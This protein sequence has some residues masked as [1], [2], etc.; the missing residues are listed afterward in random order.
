M[1]LRIPFETLVLSTGAAAVLVLGL[2]GLL[3]LRLA[4][5][6]A[7]AAQWVIH[8]EEVLVRLAKVRAETLQAELSTQNYRITGDRARLQE[9]DLSVAERELLLQQIRDRVADNP[10]QVQRWN[11]LRQ[12]V[13][14][15]KRLSAQVEKLRD[16]L[17]AQAANAFVQSAPLQQTRVRVYQTLQEMEQHERSLLALRT[18]EQAQA[19]QRVLLAGALSALMLLLLL[20]AAYLLVLRQ[21]RQTRQSQQ[22]LAHSEESLAA[23]LQSIGDGVLATDTEGRITRMNPVAER[24]TGWTLEQARGRAVE[25]VF[26]IVHEDTRQSAEVP[27]GR[28]LRTG[29]IHE[30]AEH[31]LLLARDGSVC[32]IADSAAPIRDAE[33]QLSGVVIVFR[34]ET[35][36]RQLKQSIR[37][38]NHLLEQ[39]VLERTEQLRH[40]EEH[41]RSVI[42]SVPAL[43]AFVDAEQRYVYVN[44]QYQQRFAPEHSSIIGCSVAEVLGPERYAV[45]GPLIQRALQGQAQSYDWQPFAGVW[46]QVNYLPMQ[47]N[48]GRVSGYYVLGTD[49][50]E[51]KQFEL[52]QGEAAAV[53]SNSYEAIMVVNAE[54]LITR[55][56][57]AFTRITGYSQEEV[58]G[59]SPRLLSSGRHDA[60]FFREFWRGLIE[61]GA[62]RGEI[63]NRRKN[64]DVFAVLQSVSVVRDAQ[65][66]LLHYVSV[67]ADISQIK[68]HEAELD[69]VAN[70]DSL[71]HLPNRR[72]LSDR[73]QQSILRADRSGKSCA[74][75]F[76][77][78]DG[79]KTVNDRLG[80]AVGDQIL[81]GMARHLSAI[82][83]A[84][85]TLAR[86]GGDEFVVLL[87]EVGSAE[88]CT[89]ILERMLEAAR[90][91]VQAR[92]H[93]V[94]IS[95]SVGVSLYPSDNA[96]P[97]ILLRHADMAMYLAKQAGKNRYQLFD[98]QIDRIAQNH[99]EY[100]VQMQEA[101]QRQEFMLYYQPKVD[102][103]SGAMTGA[104]ALIRW[105][106]PE[107]GLLSPAEFLPH[108]NGSHLEG[109]FGEWVLNSALAQM[110]QWHLQGLDMQVSVN[111]SANHLQQPDFCQRLAQILAQ[112]PDVDPVNLELEVLETAALADMDLAVEILERCMELGVRFAMDD[113]GT[114]Y[115]SLTYLRKLPL[116]TLK[117]D[118]SFV[119]NMLVDADDLG[120]VRGIIELASVFQRQVVAEGVETLEI[121]ARLRSLGC[122]VVQ[123]YGIARPMPAT[124]L[125]QWC[126]DWGQA[127]LWKGI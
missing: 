60:A 74:I 36:A 5:D 88:E 52:L 4:E 122:R 47:D 10:A 78:L 72:L 83:R 76:L 125:P 87:S 113:F 37:E 94:Q 46:Q 95:A 114:G 79:F 57:A 3:T 49:I 104:E 81:V 90:I 45:A 41:L 66:Q 75:C 100:L 126:T 40:S 53:F 20:A 30:M 63:W 61:D 31:T 91:P 69:R 68:A 23:T 124:A 18:A 84:E 102:L 32:P 106:Q 1:K 101:L 13:D 98:P 119:R 117:I 15:R 25:E 22:S 38:Q 62:W 120:I 7:T 43:I 77:D 89:L 56:N 8:T 116:H 9:R 33:G 27:V 118:Q 111:I 121:G 44:R 34:D 48:L 42:N 65:G 6:A 28:V 71:T 103:H 105:Q 73:L 17:G 110:H 109:V 59:Q 21:L 12:L 58:A 99:R 35:A 107:R 127:G 11:T 92:E 64:G 39:R 96:D 80:H 112:H 97:D 70:Y 86:L 85:D 19:R 51:R 108:L 54:G 55:V 82:L 14:E 67:F 26:C 115:S 93:V 24:L 2:M 123:G 29:A 16:T 50:T